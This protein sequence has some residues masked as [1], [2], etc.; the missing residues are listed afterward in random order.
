MMESS[1]QKAG[2]VRLSAAF[3]GQAWLLNRWFTTTAWVDYSYDWFS[4]DLKMC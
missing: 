3:W 4:V 2:K 1:K